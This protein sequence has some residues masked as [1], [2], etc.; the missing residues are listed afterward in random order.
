MKKRPLP[1]HC[2]QHKE[3]LSEI[4]GEVQTLPPLEYE[5]QDCFPELLNCEHRSFLHHLRVIEGHLPQG[6]FIHG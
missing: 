1:L 3:D 6:A 5:L 2:F 4:I